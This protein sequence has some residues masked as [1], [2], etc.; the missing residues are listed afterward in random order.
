MKAPVDPQIFNAISDHLELRNSPRKSDLNSGTSNQYAIE[1][2]TYLLVLLVYF[3]ELIVCML[4]ERN[5]FDSI[6]IFPKKGSASIFPEL[7]ARNLQY[8]KFD[9][10][11]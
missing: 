2:V 7:S 5:A 3:H 8:R 9:M 6:A 11:E 4:L 1:L 10:N